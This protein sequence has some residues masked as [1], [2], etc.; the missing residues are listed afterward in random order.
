MAAGF[1]NKLWG[2]IKN[3]GSGVLNA[4]DKVKE[5]GAKLIKKAMP[6]IEK[7]PVIG[8]VAK[9]VEPAIDYTATHGGK[10]LVTP[11]LEWV[12]KKAFNA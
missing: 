12:A 6:T 1:F 4:F 7:I 8:Q 3:V 11:P 2:F 5:T 10:T 9:I